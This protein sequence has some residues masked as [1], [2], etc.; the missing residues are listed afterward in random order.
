[1]QQNK[2]TKR[3][4]TA[5]LSYVE[6][7]KATSTL[8][9]ITRLFLLK[10]VFG[11]N[12]NTLEERDALISLRRD[13]IL[14]SI[15]DKIV[16]SDEAHFYVFF[17]FPSY[18]LLL[19]TFVKP[20]NPLALY[21]IRILQTSIMTEK[22]WAPPG[23]LEPYSWTTALALLTITFWIA[24]CKKYGICDKHVTNKLNTI[25]KGDMTFMHAY[26][27][28]CP[29]N[30]GLC[31]KIDEINREYGD[32]KIFLDIPYNAVYRTFEKELVKTIEKNG[33]I[34]VMAKNSLKSK[35][36]LCKICTYIQQCKYG[37]ADI[38]CPTHNIPFELGLMLGLSRNC[39]ILKQKDATIPSDISGI[40]YVEYQNTDELSSKLS[41]WIKDNTDR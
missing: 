13:I 11:K 23:R 33:L 2:A 9:K 3:A 37:L 17:Y 10:K 5:G 30:G 15:G 36:L 41:L 34:P 40:E 31:N 1:M 25:K 14:N 21:L 7:Y 18:Y 24:D 20:D 27:E 19:R 35:A 22:G 38:S 32:N 8:E 39:V 6:T 29:L 28:R 26:I 16:D 4:L 12:T